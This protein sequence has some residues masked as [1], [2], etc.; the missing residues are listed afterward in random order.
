MLT[1]LRNFPMVVAPATTRTRSWVGLNSGKTARSIARQS[2]WKTQI[3]TVRFVI[4][5]NKMAPAL[6]SLMQ[7]QEWKGLVDHFEKVRNVHLREL[8]ADDPKRG[9]RLATDALGL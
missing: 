5:D 2:K 1:T 4:K 9:E 7:R 3:L 6:A 8:F